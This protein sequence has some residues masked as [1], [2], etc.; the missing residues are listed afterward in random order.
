M[1]AS[2]KLSRRT[3][4]LGG[5]LAVSAAIAAAGFLDFPRLAR[6]RAH[7][8]YAEIVNKLSNPALAATVGRTIK[9]NPSGAAPVSTRAAA[10]DLA[11]RLANHSISELMANDASAIERIVEAD[12]WAIPLALAEICALAADSV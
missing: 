8:P 7:G 9:Q 1:N 6:R 5:A 12:R 11:A 10:S 2:P 3:M 4:A